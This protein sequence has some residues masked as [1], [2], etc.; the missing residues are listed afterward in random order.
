M[1]RRPIPGV[2]I[3]DE[4]CPDAN[5]LDASTERSDR[6]NDGVCRRACGV[7][8]S[9]RCGISPLAAKDGTN[10]DAKRAILALPVKANYGASSR[11]WVRIALVDFLL[12][13]EF[14]SSGGI[15]C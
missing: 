7:Y 15:T 9:E 11:L 12:L 4:V 6:A 5:R 1:L 3:D 10:N 8:E 2:L 14:N 13:L